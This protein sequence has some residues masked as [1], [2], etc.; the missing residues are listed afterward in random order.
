MDFEKLENNI[1]DVIKEEQAKLGYRKENIRL[2]YPLSSLCHILNVQAQPE[3]M[4]D[5][6]RSFGEY[7]RERLGRVEVSRNGERFCFLIPEQ[8]TEYVHENTE[9]DEFINKL[10][11]LVSSPGCTL[12]QVRNLFKSKSKNVDIQPINNDEFDLLIRFRDSADK[13]Y[14]C[15]KDE[16]HHVIYHRFL[17]EDYAEL[18]F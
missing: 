9:T 12:E 13:Y 5:I 8:G 18:G 4:D 2:Y 15:F 17:P 14:Y 3:E 11:L 7:T 1:A 6:L 10:V 16:G